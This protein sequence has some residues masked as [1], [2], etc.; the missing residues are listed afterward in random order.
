VITVDESGVV[1]DEDTVERRKMEQLEDMMSS[2]GTDPAPISHLPRPGP[3]DVK[4]IRVRLLQVAR[5]LG[6]E[7]G[8]D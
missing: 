8:L 5:V 4:A 1:Q 6:L 2:F 7:L 3:E